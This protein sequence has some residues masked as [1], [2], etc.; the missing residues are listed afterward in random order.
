MAGGWSVSPLL[1]ASKDWT[2]VGVGGTFY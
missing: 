2:L 1:L